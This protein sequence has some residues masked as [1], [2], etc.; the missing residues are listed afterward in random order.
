MA[1]YDVAAYVESAIASA[2][3]QTLGDLE[4]IVVDDGSS[5]GTADLAEGMADPRVRVIRLSHAGPAPALNRG[6]AEAKGRYVA[7]FDG[8]DLWDRNKLHAQVSLMDD[9]PDVDLTFCLSGTIDAQGRD[10]GMT[11]RP[12]VGPVPF[13]R[14]LVDNIIACGSTVVLRKSALL[15]VGSFDASLLAAQ[16]W[17]LWLRMAMRRPG[18]VWCVPEVLTSYRRRQGQITRDWRLMYDC[19]T[20][21]YQRHRGQGRAKQ[22]SLEREARCNLFRYLAVLNYELGHGRQGL[23]LLAR[24]FAASPAKFLRTQRSYL[25]LGALLARTLLPEAAFK[26]LERAV[27]GCSA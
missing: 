8:D 9:R 24:S 21:V 10:L 27:R 17:D 2:L 1:V 6:I 4:V 11:S 25:V 16:D 26:A 13:E 18:N 20:K 12:W 3:A 19:L 22:A 15:D 14:L 7:I 5:D 23:A